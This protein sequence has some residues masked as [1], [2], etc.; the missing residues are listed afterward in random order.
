MEEIA[1]CTKDY[2]EVTM[3]EIEEGEIE[4]GERE[5]CLWEGKATND[6]NDHTT[7]RV[8]LRGNE[9]VINGH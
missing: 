2:S 3:E 8:F 1:Q 4:E 5:C 6:S 7:T 9:R